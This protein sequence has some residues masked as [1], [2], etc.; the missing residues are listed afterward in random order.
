MKELR[1]IEVAPT[2]DAFEKAQRG[3]LRNLAL[4]TGAQLRELERARPDL[5]VIEGESA[6]I[7]WPASGAIN[8]Q[9]GYPGHNAFAEQ[10]SPMLQRLLRAVDA[11]EAPIG[12]CLR[13]TE[14][15]VRSYVEPVLFA[16]AFELV[17]EFWEMTLAELPDPSTGSGQALRATGDELASGFLLRPARI[18]DA[19]AIAELDAASFTIPSLTPG[20]AREQIEQAPVLRVLEDTS[21]GRTIGYLQLGTKQGG[22]YVSELVVH[23]GYQ[24]RGLG[25]AMLRWALAW[26]RSQG[27]TSAALTVTTDNAPAIA[28]YRKLGFAAGDIG[29]D[30]RRPIDEDEVR[31]VLEKGRAEHITVR[32]R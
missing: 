17:R 3:A 1:R 2:A 18:A 8:L 14:R 12:V 32:R 5:V 21:S 26:F 19:E 4:I 25:E 29:L 31:Q 28:L 13:L 23:A 30:Y 27:L 20:V 24:R 11:A 22:G 16:N 9:Y 6:L 10:F 7:G 15:S